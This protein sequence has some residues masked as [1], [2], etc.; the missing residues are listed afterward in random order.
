VLEEVGIQVLVESILELHLAGLPVDLVGEV[1]VGSRLEFLAALGGQGDIH[2]LLAIVADV[3]L[4][5]R[6]DIVLAIAL[7]ALT[8]FSPNGQSIDV[9]LVPVLVLHGIGECLGALL[10]QG[11]HADDRFGGVAL[12]LHLVATEL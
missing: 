2:D 12:E 8:D 5:V 7:V 1:D 3:E 4:L 9:H 11:D 6:E 10:L